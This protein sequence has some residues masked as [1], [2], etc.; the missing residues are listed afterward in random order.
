MGIGKT[1]LSIELFVWQQREWS[2]RTFGQGQRTEGICKHIEKELAEIRE[3][4]TDI[5]E[6]IDV[7]ILAFD[8]AWRAGYSPEEIEEALYDKQQKNFLRK[9]PTNPAEDQPSEHI[10]KS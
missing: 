5:T 4:P 1:Y 6:W 8:G 3:N 7:I 2:V 9:W 10:R